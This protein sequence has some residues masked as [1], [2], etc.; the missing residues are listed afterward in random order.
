MDEEEK[1]KEEEEEGE[2]KRKVS[3]S[4]KN[5]TSLQFFQKEPSLNR[6]SIVRSYVRSYMCLSFPFFFFPFPLP[7]DLKTKQKRIASNYFSRY[8]DRSYRSV[9][10]ETDRGH[11]VGRTMGRGE[12]EEEEEQEEQEQE[13]NVYIYIYV[14]M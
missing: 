5:E 1:E 6:S 13:K 3:S 7:L 10:I 12:E 4:K 14:C 9:E 2:I 8:L 11:F